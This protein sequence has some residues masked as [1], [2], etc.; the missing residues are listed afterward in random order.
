MGYGKKREKKNN[1]HRVTVGLDPSSTNRN[2]KWRVNC[3]HHGHV[4]NHRKKST[5]IQ[6]ARQHARGLSGM[7]IFKVQITNGQWRTESTYP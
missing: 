6:R 1:P 4:S 7:A 2:Q 3:S 5:A